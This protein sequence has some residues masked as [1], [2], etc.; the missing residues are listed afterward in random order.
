MNAAHDERPNPR[1]PGT[2][3]GGEERLIARFSRLPVKRIGAVFATLTIIP[4]ALLAYFSVSLSHDALSKEVEARIRSTS[5]ISATFV[6]EEMLLLTELVD[7]Y[8]QR[9]SLIEA[10]GNGNA[11]RN[12]KKALRVQLAELV[13]R[14]TI[15][16][17]FVADPSGRLIDILPATPSIIGDDFSFRDWYRG[18]TR[19]GRPYVS[20]AYRS[21]VRGHPRV[22]AAA[23]PMY[24]RGHGGRGPMIAIF[25]VAYSLDTIQEFANDFARAQGVSLTITDQRGVVIAEPGAAPTGLVSRR[26]DPHVAAALE[27]RSGVATHGGSTGKV[28]SAYAPIPEIGWTVGAEVPASTAFAPVSKLRATVVPIAAVLGLIIVGALTLL[29]LTLRER[30][31]MEGMFQR[32]EERAR[33]I[34]ADLRLLL[35][36]SGEGIYG[37]DLEGRVTFINKSAA[38]A[39][40]Y[41]PQA[42][43][44]MNSHEL[45]HHSRADNSPYPVEECPI[46]RAFRIGRGCRVDKEVLWR[47]DGTSFS[48]EYSSHPIIDDGVVKGAVVTFTDITERRATERELAMTHDQAMEASRLKSEFLANMS[49]EI[50]TPMNG[51]IGMTGL[52]LDTE[53]TDE[54]REFV[55]V[56]RSSGDALLNLINDILD[57]SKIEAGKM[58][59]E[60][61]DFDLRT[62]V[63][64]VIELLAERAHAKDLELAAL[65]HPRV[66][67]A[68]RGDAG[69]VRQIL[70]NL[71]GNAVK[72]TNQGEVVVRVR[73]DE[74][75]ETDA[76]IRFEVTDT[77]IG[78]ASEQ[79]T[80]VFESFI[81]ADASSIRKFAGT[82][83]G[84]AI[85]KQLAE[86]MSG[87]IGVESELGTGSTFWFTARLEKGAVASRGGPVYPVSLRNLPVLVV[88]DNST[89]RAVLEQSLISWGMR[90]SSAESGELALTMLRAAGGSNEQF[91][92]AILDYNM[93]DMDGMELARQV[94]LDPAIGHVRLVLLTSSG[95]QGQAREARKIGFD[96]YL[97]KPVRQAA[98]YDCLAA[99]MGMDDAPYPPRMVTRHTIAE[100]K[101]GARAH[102]LVVEDNPVNQTVTARML[103]RMGH[104]VDV[105]ANGTEAVDSIDRG[106][107]AVVLMDCQMPEMDGYEAT[108]EIR[109]REGPKRHLPII[110]MTAGAMKGD[111]EKCLAAGMDDY[112]AKPVRIEELQATLAH[113]LDVQSQRSEA[114]DK[115]E[116]G[117]AQ[118][119]TPSPLDATVLTRLKGLENETGELVKLFLES[120][121]EGVSRLRQ[122]LARRDAD[123][124]AHLAHALKGSVANLGAMKMADLCSELEELA[125]ASELDRAIDLIEHVDDEFHHVRT[126][127]AEA[128]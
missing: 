106:N 107:Y 13:S 84:L 69:R 49:H 85:A 53:L 23:A 32:S 26:D 58:D 40:G 108:I 9:P 34:S 111:A 82:G 27:G 98:L 25:V 22:V 105:A 37:I 71:I 110:A 95:K 63:E 73:L 65:V 39:F 38:E 101:V 83:L 70:M 30:R 99:V 125:L 18:V 17:A 124:T 114:Q 14:R 81:Q 76:L 3:R 75:T 123:A 79:Q 91:A 8:A 97:T 96:A 44:G 122:A 33:S 42:V 80:R 36:S 72:F 103:E 62:A 7:S 92:I 56:I 115:I 48:A 121:A 46:F 51:V 20:E 45:F 35:E 78:L 16:T 28:L 15:A 68:V 112:L 1:T 88:D 118:I 100:D 87:D 90:P 67:T 127:L 21:A 61:I 12:D 2:T 54:Q 24:A 89:N 120:A 128:S 57:F 47:R 66:P 126:A 10:L 43:L 50:R 102:I 19:T 11:G 86:L 64:D 93:P 60:V 4:L 104:R 41:E 55:E 116:I 94:T 74:E 109:K 77:G 5:V 113:W 29:V 52:L 6:R 117:G 119:P 31:R 59:L